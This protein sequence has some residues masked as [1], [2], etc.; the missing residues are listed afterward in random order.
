MH[1]LN[2]LENRRFSNKSVCVAAIFMLLKQM[3]GISVPLPS[4]P[5]TKLLMDHARL[6]GSYSN[7]KGLWAPAQALQCHLGALS[8]LGRKME[9]SCSWLSGVSWRVKSWHRDLKT[10]PIQG[11]QLVCVHPRALRTWTCS[12]WAIRSLL[13]ALFPVFLPDLLQ[14]MN[15]SIILM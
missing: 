11:S 12:S 1:F 8:H 6:T 5:A 2:R 10:C 13:S 14:H 7:D 15:C 4:S 3:A 9:S